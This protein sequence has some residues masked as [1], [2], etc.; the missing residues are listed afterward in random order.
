MPMHFVLAKG[1]LSESSPPNARWEPGHAV[2]RL[3]VPTFEMDLCKTQFSPAD[4]GEG[5]LDAYVL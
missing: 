2:P 5:R 3:R 4:R 1:A